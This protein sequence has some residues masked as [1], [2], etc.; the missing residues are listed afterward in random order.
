M[1]WTTIS[2]NGAN[3]TTT[4]TT[5]DG[6][7]ITLK[8]IKSTDALEVN[9]TNHTVT[10]G[11]DSLGSTSV[12]ISV[13]NA[14]GTATAY[15]LALDSDVNKDVF[16]WEYSG[17]QA[18]Y[19]QIRPTQFALNS[20]GTEITKTNAKSG[21]ATIA[22]VSGIK[23]GLDEVFYTYDDYGEID[24][25]IYKADLTKDELKA[26][27]NEKLSK[28]LVINDS[29][30][31]ITV[32]PSVFGTKS[33]K[34]TNGTGVG[35]SSKKTYK[36]DI[37]GTA[38]KDYMSGNEEKPAVWIVSGTTAKYYNNADDFATKPGYKLSD[39]EITYTAP[40]LTTKPAPEPAITI[41]KLPSGLVP[42]ATGQ[43]DGLEINTV[44][45][46]VKIADALIFNKATLTI[47]GQDS[48]GRDYTFV[49][50]DNSGVVE[51]PDITVE[52]KNTAITFTLESNA[53]E[54]S[55][56]QNGKAIVYAKNDNGVQIAKLTGVVKDTNDYTFDA[57]AAFDEETGVITLGANDLGKSKVTITGDAGYTLDVDGT[58]QK[59][60]TG[61]TPELVLNKTTATYGV[62]TTEGYGI[63]DDGKSISYVKDSVKAQATITGVNSSL[64][65][66]AENA[67]G[68]KL[69]EEQIATRY[70]T[71]ID[72]ADD[73][74]AELTKWI[75]YE[76]AK[77]EAAVTAKL[78]DYI[79]IDSSTKKITLS[80]EALGTSNIKL[81]IAS[82]ADDY[83]LALGEGVIQSKAD[84]ELEANYVTTWEVKGTN[85]TYQTYKPAY[86]TTKSSKSGIKD[87]TCSKAVAVNKTPDISLS[88]LKKNLA[89]VNNAIAGI[90][91]D[92]T[93]KTV[94]L[95]EDVLPEKGTV[96]VAK[97][98]YTIKLGDNVTETTVIPKWNEKSGKFELK[99]YKSEGYDLASDGKSVTYISES[100]ASK[101]PKVSATL[102]NLNG[103]SVSSGEI[104][105]ITVDTEKATIT[106]NDS[107]LLGKVS[108]N[109]KVTVTGSGGFTLKLGDEAGA[110]ETE[111]K[112]VIK[113]GKAVLQQTYTNGVAVSA[114]GKSIS[115]VSASTKAVELLTISG[116]NSAV[117]ADALNSDLT[118]STAKY[119]SVG[120]DGTLTLTKAAVG[121]SAIKLTTKG[122]YTLALADD[123][124]QTEDTSATSS[125]W[126][127][128]GTEATY[129][130][131]AEGYYT[132]DAKK[133]SI[134]Y[135]SPKASSGSAVTV[136]L[137]GLNK[138]GL[139]VNGDGTI[140]G[141]TYNPER[142]STIKL[143]TEVLGTSAVT[144]EST[145]DIKLDLA[146]G[147]KKAGTIY[148]PVWT[149]KKTTVTLT[150]EPPSGYTVATDKKS[151]TYTAGGSNV[152]MATIT[153]LS[154]NLA[155]KLG[156]PYTFKGTSYVY[157]D[158]TNL[159]K[160]MVTA[161]F[162][163]GSTNV[164]LKNGKQTDGTASTYT[165]GLADTPTTAEKIQWY[166]KKGSSTAQYINCAVDH[167]ELAK[168]DTQIVFKALAPVEG[169]TALITVDGI[170]KNVAVDGKIS[171]TSTADGGLVTLSKDLLNYNTTPITLTGTGIYANYTLAL[172]GETAATP[173][174]MTT[175][176]STSSTT[177]TLKQ[178]KPAGYSL[179]AD[180]KT[181]S[182][183]SAGK[184]VTVATV[185]GLASGKTMT[186]KLASGDV[187]DLALDSTKLSNKV[188]VDGVGYTFKFDANYKDSTI[189]GSTKVETIEAKGTGLTVNLGKG[190]DVVTFAAGRSTGDNTF[191][192][193]SGDGDDTINNYVAGD[194]IKVNLAS[195]AFTAGATVE[196]GSV[197]LSIKRGNVTGKITLAGV[198][199]TDNISVVN[200]KD[201]AVTLT[202]TAASS[203]IGS[204]SIGDLLYSD[205]YATASEL[206][207]IVSGSDITN[208]S[209]GDIETDSATDLTKQSVI[210]ASSGK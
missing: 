102:T 163:E 46:T 7:V 91:I 56:L 193:N 173:A 58:V 41:T 207:D 145:A 160:I 89:V 206:G 143:G 158:E 190:N 185:K 45:T 129:Q 77:Y 79:K 68:D 166:V 114:D 174:S 191:L 192:Y 136:T 112:W 94:T 66:I 1:A 30:N 146:D 189:L 69:T 125:G 196:D 54:Y 128:K 61:T 117:T 95:A 109:T 157:I 141:I 87:I 130:N 14:E 57:D 22:T 101:T 71:R 60:E 170:K 11:Q 165:F 142:S 184:D 138:N 194:K 137:K 204:D 84:S 70:A 159:S 210:V 131:I 186:D 38:G 121:S 200:N 127:V 52:K 24:E 172:N 209:V 17:E 107:S 19:K 99:L 92:A 156:D 120:S 96:K 40:K 72:K 23:K 175:Q 25:V 83:D 74:D 73:P 201:E 147:V 155:D 148:P 65:A 42:D 32:D 140:T 18:T 29:E 149:L 53:E 108:G 88:G 9:E 118:A 13:A 144:V 132:L 21:T 123:V 119:I 64:R 181:L 139:K 67:V 100:D 5:T 63:A 198:T 6:T 51:D 104:D 34:L 16:T 113:N 62:H 178:T 162:L 26:A 59:S 28:L 10:V 151:I 12:S 81:K 31:E 4:Y 105:G 135:T 15:K 33:I 8:G 116:L 180:G 86:Y 134:A 182:Y 82:G 76:N 126:V 208:F 183:L 115:A 85:A 106:I 93:K 179:S 48:D 110:A 124:R 98:D 2:G 203:L 195:T 187:T 55:L 3:A 202:T 171:L 122:A 205:N 152:T 27:V 44:T 177:A 90:T 103:A 47:S 50:D 80:K 35:E 169:A 97:G 164:T 39:T 37:K 161:D 49:L 20:T 36:F 78:A 153:G 188:T 176:W 111:E 150:Q 133:T 197:V 199:S 168:N 154:S 43:I 75:N 167:Y